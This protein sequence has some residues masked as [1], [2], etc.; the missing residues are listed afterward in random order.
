MV[1]LQDISE[2]RRA[3]EALSRLSRLA[4]VVR[5]TR[6]AITVQ[7]RDGRLLTWSPG[8]ERIYGWS[9]AEALR[10]NVRVRMPADRHEAELAKL[11]ELCGAETPEF[12]RTQRIAKSGAV[13]AVSIIATAL[14]NQAGQMYAIATTERVIGGGA[15]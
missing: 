9:E 10:M 4:V 11:R 13:V 15:A 14:F 8:A 7:D 1:F 2:R 3:E 5:D 6:D 12:Y